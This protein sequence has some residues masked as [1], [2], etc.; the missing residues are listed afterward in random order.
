M[1]SIVLSK[2]KKLMKT[3]FHA[4]KRGGKAPEVISIC[5][6]PLLTLFHRIACFFI[7]LPIKTSYHA[8]PLLF[9]VAKS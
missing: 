4:Q 9:N 6:S 7:P 8:A 2:E 3:R 1:V 5:F